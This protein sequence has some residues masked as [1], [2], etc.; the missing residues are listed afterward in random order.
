MKPITAAAAF[1]TGRYSP[2]SNEPTNP[3]KHPLS[4]PDGSGAALQYSDSRTGQQHAWPPESGGPVRGDAFVNLR[5]AM[6]KALNTPFAQVELASDVGLA[7]VYATALAVGMPNGSPDLLQVASL[8]LGTA[9]ESPLTMASVYG[10]FADGGIRHDPAFVF[11][12]KDARDKMVWQPDTTGT[13][14]LSAH[15]ADEVG[16]MLRSVLG[17]ESVTGAPS[18]PALSAKG[19]AAMAGTADSD[20]AAWFDGYGA[21]LVTAVA[22]SRVDSNGNAAKITGGAEGGRCGAGRC[23]GR[24]GWSSWRSSAIDSVGPLTRAAGPVGACGPGR[25]DGVSTVRPLA[26]LGSVR[27]AKLSEQVPCAD[28]QRNATR[29][30][31]PSGSPPDPAMVSWNCFSVPLPWAR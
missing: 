16:D 28:D 25:P 13:R 30:A 15:T 2:D 29:R 8:T 23:W 11:M 9:Q 26:R 14:V 4:W 3:D 10:V 19:F 22:L 21:D 31:S 1:E 18:A 7:K 12:V 5:E 20:H 24:C 6:V 27:L 17:T